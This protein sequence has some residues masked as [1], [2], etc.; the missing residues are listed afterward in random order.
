MPCLARLCG[1]PGPAAHRP[2]SAGIY[3]GFCLDVIRNKYECELQ[4][5]KQHLEVNVGAPGGEEVA[6]PPRPAQLSHCTSC[7]VRSCCCTTRCRASCRSGSRGWRRTARAWTSTL[8]RPAASRH[9]CASSA[10]SPSGPCLPRL[11]GG[12]CR[13]ACSVLTM[14]TDGKQAGKGPARCLVH[15][16]SLGVPC[17]PAGPR[18]EASF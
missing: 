3:K 14:G 2:P 8:V 15:S 11:H 6:A 1:Q 10:R 16:G 17:L 13:R 5:A 9:P 18:M 4:G 12:G 7:R